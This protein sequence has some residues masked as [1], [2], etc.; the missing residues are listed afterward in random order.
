M[1]QIEPGNYWSHTLGLDLDDC[2]RRVY[3]RVYGSWG[4]WTR[5]NG[6]TPH[7]LYQAK[8]SNNLPTYVGG[9][10]H[11]VIQRIIERVR[12]QLRLAQ[13]DLLLKRLEERMRWEIE[14]SAQGKWRKLDNPKKAS[15]ILQQHL[16]GQDLHRPQIEEAIDRARSALLVFLE[17]YLPYI[18][19]LKPEQISLIDS[20]DSISHRGFSLFMSPDLVISRENDRVII[21]WKT[22]VHANV[23][24]L[25]VYS[26][27][28]V[29][30][31]ER[32]K[33]QELDPSIITGRS[34]PLL[35]P[36]NEAVVQMSQADLDE[37]MARINRDI[38]TIVLHHDAGISRDELAFPKT[39]HTGQC[40]H[41]AFQFYCDLR[42]R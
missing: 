25:K 6:A 38:D 1:G 16:L 19:T 27:Y 11:Y 29:H 39:E 4:G 24:Q 21:D 42:P 17:Q 20:L 26:T 33:L 3:Y 37:A 5:S 13:D 34:V 28:L 18:R 31:E 14:Y 40:S 32:E 36:E 7:L 10:V 35:H 15:L 30:W 12:A 23:D 41:C 22:G 2:L 9:L 8:V